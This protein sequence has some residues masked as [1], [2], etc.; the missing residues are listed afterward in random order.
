MKRIHKLNTPTFGLAEYLAVVGDEANWDGFCSHRSSTAS[1]RELK[2]ALIQ[3]QHGLCAY[4]ETEIGGWLSQVEHVIPQSDNRFG[5]AKA[6]DIAN[7]VAS[8]MGGTLE[9]R[10]VN[11]DEALYR[12]PVARNMSCGQAKGE[13]HD[14]CFIMRTAANGETDVRDGNHLRSQ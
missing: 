3:N 10:S 7:M 14:G 11:E 5:K 2:N 6:L 12:E 9:V 1:L 13:Q 8:C 4:C